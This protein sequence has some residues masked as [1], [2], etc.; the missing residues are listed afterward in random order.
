L[1]VD[2]EVLRVG[3]RLSAR[4]FL[5][6]LVL[7]PLAVVVLLAL[8]GALLERE[9]VIWLAVAGA[10]VTMLLTSLLFLADPRTH[11]PYD[12]L[13]IVASV[14]AVRRASG[15]VTNRPVARS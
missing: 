8:R 2:Y 15:A 11:I 1:A 4:G 10:I 14:A 5:F 12:G 6:V 3:L 9:H 7:P 13:L